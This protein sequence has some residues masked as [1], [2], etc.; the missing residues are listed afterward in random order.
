VS[1]EPERYSAVKVK[2]KPAEEMKQITASVFATGKVI[3]TGACTLKEIAYAYNIVASTIH[4]DPSL[5]V[6]PTAKVDVFDRYMGYDTGKMVRALRNKGHQSWV[7][8]I[9]NKQI[10]FSACN[11]NN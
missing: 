2:F 4:S 3:I 8:T 11:N 9:E 6:K 1:F 10:N 5:A 7:R